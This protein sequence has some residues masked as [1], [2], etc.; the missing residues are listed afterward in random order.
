[1][2][3][4]PSILLITYDLHGT[5]AQQA[6]FFEVLRKDLW[7]HYIGGTWLIS[8]KKTPKELTEDLKPLMQ[9]EDRL[10]V[11][12]FTSDYWGWLPKDAW[13]WIAKNSSVGVS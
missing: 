9:T 7:W 6:A 5:A 1:V 10:M 13:E 8:T 11:V 2:N 4:N 12:R 3:L